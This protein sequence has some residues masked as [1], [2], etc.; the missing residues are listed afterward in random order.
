MTSTYIG[1]SSRHSGDI[2]LVS[3]LMACGIPLDVLDPVSVVDRHPHP[4]GSYNFAE[5]SEDGTEDVDTL[6]GHW[7][8]TQP[9]PADHGFAA[10]C[11]FIRARPKG[12]QRS[13]DLLDFAAE[14][15]EQ[16]GHRLA[17]LR[18]MDDVPAFVNA[19]PKGEAAYVLAYVWN[20][21]L[22]FQLY[23]GASKKLFFEEGSGRDTRRALIDARL[24]QWQARE[25]LSRLQG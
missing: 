10:I 16:Q 21:E 19:L 12:I 14:Y 6:L 3:A 2:N 15:L 1:T 24:P 11:R 18:R 17:G 5:Y 20:R 22:C 23:R 4:Y 9:L 25:I 13:A 8:G 7:S